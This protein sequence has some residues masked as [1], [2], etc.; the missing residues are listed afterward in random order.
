M[1]TEI[2]V[3]GNT[4]TPAGDDNRGLDSNN[5][6]VWL[7]TSA[8]YDWQSRVVREINTD[9]T[10]KLISYEGCGC[11]G[12]Q[13]TT[14][15]SELV[16]RDD[17]PNTLARRTQKIYQ[18]ILGR[19]YKT[20]ALNWDSNSP[21][22]TIVETFN[23]KDQV[24]S[25]KTFNGAEPANSFC[26]IGQCQ[27][28]KNTYDGFGRLK[29]K[30]LPQQDA[31]KYTTYNYYVDDS[32][33]SEVDARGVVTNYLY[34]SRGLVENVSYTIPT[35]LN[36]PTT[37]TVVFNYDN[38]GNRTSMIDGLGSVSYEYNE[39]SQMTAETRQFNDHL[40][41]A[42]LPNNSFRLEYEYDL[43]GQLK[44]LT[45]PL[46]LEIGYTY[47]RTGKLRT[48]SGNSSG[49]VTTYVSN[50]EY[51]A[52]GALKHLEYGNGQQAHLTFN[53]RLQA[54]GFNLDKSSQMLMQKQY[55][56]YGD[57]TLRLIQ[58]QLD[59][60]FNR[61]NKYDHVGR[62]TEARSGVEA[63]GQ[64][65]TNLQNLPYRQFYTHDVF[66]HTTGRANTNWGVQYDSGGS[67]I[68]DR[69]GDSTSIWNGYDADGRLLT[70][71]K[72]IYDY[73]ETIENNQ[74]VNIALY[75]HDETAFDATG[76]IVSLK[77][78]K[79]IEKSNPNPP[80]QQ[81]QHRNIRIR[82]YRSKI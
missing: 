68:N 60:K 14:V 22:S 40:P 73:Y 55:D 17:Q 39:L 7:W 16:P 18:D 21:N 65:E 66:G 72:G 79:T 41:N 77:A 62:L 63:V 1:P 59:S 69:I 38:I 56:Y 47:D 46:G 48:V 31:N 76:K 11:A 6:P 64:I 28:I 13:V 4:W 44:T 27:E 23:D 25:S 8:E 12:G 26:L 35:N 58:D 61:L 34:N 36:I 82:P 71:M 19:N 45:N 24:T 42:P 9:G 57:G 75:N 5:N 78:M 53:N 32:L 70:G 50:A 20:E 49:S 10:D 3:S 51:R 43:S 74:Q 54:S 80:H 2:S 15:Q 67:Y 33:S 81:L 29:T 37:P 30:H 52:W